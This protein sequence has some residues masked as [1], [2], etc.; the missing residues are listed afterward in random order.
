MSTTQP[1]SVQVTEEMR[2]LLTDI[3]SL[4]FDFSFEKEVQ[5]IANFC[6]KREAA[7]LETINLQ[8]DEAINLLTRCDASEKELITLREANDSL[9]KQ[10]EA[11]EAES[12]RFRERIEAYKSRDHD[13]SLGKEI[14]GYQDQI[15]KLSRTLE[16]YRIRARKLYTPEEAGKRLADHEDS[17]IKDD[18]EVRLL[19][20]YTDELTKERDGLRALAKR[21]A[22]GLHLSRNGGDAH[23]PWLNENQAITVN[24][25]LAEAQIAGLL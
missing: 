8:R 18:S 2:Q 12:V 19:R 6:A 11:A 17:I 9:A 15:V 1:Q 21:L 23:T 24:E 10:V 3:Q 25:V 7:L 22:E 13:D 16:A 4:N 5:R 20:I 14:V